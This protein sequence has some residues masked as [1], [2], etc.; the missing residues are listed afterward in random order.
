[1]TKIKC[2]IIDDEPPSHIVLKN[3]IAKVGQL[4]WVFSSS[5]PLQ[6]RDYLR[7]HSVD[8]LFLD[9]EMPELSGLELLDSLQSRPKVVIIS[10]H[11]EYAA[12]SY[13][14]DAVDYLVK[15]FTFSRFL[16]AVDKIIASSANTTEEQLS[17]GFFQFKE[18]GI[19]KK[20]KH[21]EVLYLES[22]GNYIKIVT[23]AKTHLIKKTMKELENE[24]SPQEFVRVHKSF[25]VNA[26][27]ITEL[28]SRKLL[29]KDLE[30]PVGGYYKSQLDKL[31]GEQ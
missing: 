25:M 11:S 20:V 15:P 1:M 14:Y 3:Y 10:A 29:L 12:K 26:K 8:L 13:E 23:S 16:K 9:V 5:N 6:A 24:L 21:V 31:F 19:P 4:V 7:S 18:N 22:I 2:V 30:I 17:D 28:S 27:M